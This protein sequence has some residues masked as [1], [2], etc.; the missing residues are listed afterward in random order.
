MGAT[1]ATRPKVALPA[2]AVTTELVGLL[3]LP[4]VAARGPPVV[5]AGEGTPEEATAGRGTV[6]FWGRIVV[7]PVGRA[8]P[9][10]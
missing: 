7:Q 8:A 5:A 10:G 6:P 4:V 9:E 1:A 3:P 2:P